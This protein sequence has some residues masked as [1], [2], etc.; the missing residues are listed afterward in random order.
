[1]NYTKISIIIYG[2]CSDNIKNQNETDIDYGGICGRCGNYTFYS[3]DTAFQILDQANLINRSKPFNSTLCETGNANLGA[4]QFFLVLIVIGLF[5]FGFLILFL[6]APII[7][8]AITG[9]YNFF[10]WDY[11]K[12]KSR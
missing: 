12:K 2:D 10:I 6:L 11:F 5:I 3:D 9:K 1:V 4:I 8:F 7:L